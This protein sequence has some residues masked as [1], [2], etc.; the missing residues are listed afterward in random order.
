M[1]G[2]NK[3]QANNMTCN[4]FKIGYVF[5]RYFI[6]HYADL[7]IGEVCSGLTMR[8]TQVRN[9]YIRGLL[10]LNETSGKTTGG[11]K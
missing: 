3:R 2:I 5:F 11:H 1:Y 9:Q 6:T 7:L 8:E 10:P 4:R